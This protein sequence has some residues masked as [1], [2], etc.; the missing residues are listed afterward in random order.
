MIKQRNNVI[1]VLDIGSS[2]ISCMIAK[3]S[4]SSEL[5]I[6]GSSSYIASGIRSGIITDLQAATESIATTIEGAEKS[7]GIRIHNLYVN[8]AAN[9]LISHQLSAE[10]DVTGHEINS[11]DINKLLLQIL[12]KYK[13]QQVSVIHSFIYDY[14]LDGNRGI[15]NPLG[16]YS[17]TLACEVNVLVAPNNVVANL[18]NCLSK[19]QIDVNGYIASSYVSGLACLSAD[20][21]KVG[22]ILIEIGAGC[23][24][25][26][27]FNNSKLI[28]TD[29]IPVGGHHITNDIA[30]GLSISYEDAE[31]IKILYGTAVSISIESKE[32]IE[33]ASYDDTEEINL[34]P[35]ATLAEIIRARAEEILELLERKLMHAGFSI[36]GTKIVLTGGSAHL[37]GLKELVNHM[38]TA[39]VRM[40]YPKQL[41]GLSTDN[42]NMIA[43]TAIG[44]LMY[45]LQTTKT[46]SISTTSD[47]MTGKKIW[48]WLKDNFI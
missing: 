29:G 25:I 31:R 23:S 21:M 44:M 1:A 43:N 46:T 40:G 42:K 11:K 45:A 19:C 9:N 7:S 41:S 28:F 26:S 48:Q 38:F 37:N 14:T 33:L 4:A 39:K 32:S 16:M 13:E 3:F 36:S 12:D 22:V 17:S 24:S 5:E 18:A 27:I 47:K 30:K 6:L 2:K 15:T 34:I 20:E 10:I 8:I 35:R